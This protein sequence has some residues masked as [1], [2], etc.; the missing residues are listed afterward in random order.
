MGHEYGARVRRRSAH[1]RYWFG[2]VDGY[3]EIR[4]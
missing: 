4:E 1:R 3:E 2:H